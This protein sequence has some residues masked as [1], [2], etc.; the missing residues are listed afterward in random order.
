V[1]SRSGFIIALAAALLSGVSLG[2][3]AGILSVKY[4]LRAWTP[5]AMEHHR[6]PGGPGD[7]G[8]PGGPGGPGGVPPGV[9]RLERELDLNQAQRDSVEAIVQRSHARFE[10]MRDS[11]RH[12]IE[13]QLTPKQREQ[14]RERQAGPWHGRPWPRPHDGDRP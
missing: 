13:A 2:L 1:I 3:I 8:G 4:V 6:G 11:L 12:Q 7:H 10:A 14:W 9:L 5:Y